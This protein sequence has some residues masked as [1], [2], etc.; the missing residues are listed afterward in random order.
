MSNTQKIHWKRLSAEAIAIVASILLAFSIDAWWEERSDRV[1]LEG[2]VQNIAAEINEAREEIKNAV[3]RNNFRI[4]GM[5]RFMALDSDELLTLSQDSI[6]SIGYAITT[7]SPFDTSGFALQGLLA[8]GNLESIANEELGSALIVWAQFPAE[9]ERDYAETLQLSLALF[10]RM[11]KHGV[12]LALTN[13]TTELVIPG[14]VQLRETLASLRRDAEA[15]GT[16]AQFLVYFEDFNSQL[17]EGI[18]YADQVIEA[19]RQ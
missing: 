14:V 7:P 15:V 10:E 18:E 8:G 6:V 12:Y 1:R 2:A 16:M 5:K 4:D 17:A 13:E 11:A 3:Q 19:S 9:I